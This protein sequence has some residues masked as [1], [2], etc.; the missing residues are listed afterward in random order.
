MISSP[1]DEIKNRL[2]VV[3][4]IGSYIKLQKAGANFR[5][6]CPF[7]SEKNPSLFISPARQIWHC[8]G[9]FL[10]G[11]LIKT[12]RG[13]HE[14]EDIRVGERVLTHEGNYLPVIR[15]LWRPYQGEII[16]IKLRKSNEITSL[17]P[18][19]EVYVIKTKH[20]KYESR[21][22]RI[23]QWNCRRC[24]KCKDG[25]LGRF[26]LNYKIEKLPVAQLSKDDYLLYPINQEI[27]DIEFIDLNKYYNRRISNFGPDIKEIPTFVK[28]DE[29]FLK[30]IGY[31]IAE[32]SNHRAYIRFSLGDHEKEF[33]KEI[34]ELIRD[35][36]G[37]KAAIHK[38]KK[39][40]K[41]GLEISACNS[42]L[43]NIFE[44]LCG[45]HG[46]NK[47]ILFK[48]QY[49]SPEKQRIIL[50]AIWRG[51]GTERKVD[52]CKRER[53]S[54]SISTTS[55]ILAEQLR[56]ILLR[57]KIA[58]AFF[59][60]EEKIDKKGVHHKK[61][62]II[63]WEENYILNY[64]GFYQ[65]GEILY[66]LCPIKEI[67]KR[68]Y[69]GDTFDLTIAKDHSYVAANFLV[70]NCG[71]GGDIFGFVKEI[72]GV[73]FG[74]ALRILARRA[75][76][77]LKREDP[78]I[79]T[80]RRR[81]YEICELSTQFF[82]K[83]LESKT[84]QEVNDYLRKRGINQESIEKWRLG[85][86]PDSWNSLSDFLVSKGY[87][88]EEIER[89]G[90]VIKNESGN[91][92]DRFRGRIIFPVFDLNSQVIGFGGR[93][94]SVNQRINQ[95]ESASTIAKYVNTPNTSLYDKS[96]VL[97]GL[98]KAKVEIRKKDF[99]ILVEG[100]VDV[101]M[102]HQTG[103]ENTAATSGTALSP[104]QLAILK[105]YSE[106]I[107]TAFDMDVAGDWATKRGIDLAQA[108]GFD[109]KV[110]TMPQDSDPADIISQN[111]EKW[112]ELVEKAKSI[113]DFYFESAFS[114]FD[115]KP[116][117]GKKE[118]SKILLPVIKRIPNK[119]EQSFWVQKLA[120]ELEVGEGDVAE[121]LN[122]IKLTEEVYGLEPEEIV[123][124]PSKT[125][126]ELLEERLIT[127]ILISK[128]P[129]YLESI[130]EAEFSNFS[131]KSQEILK[132]L[133]NNKISQ[134]G[135]D[136]SGLSPESVDLLNY[137][138]LK[139]EIEEIEK[140]EI[141][142]EIKYCIKEIRSIEIKNKLD[143]ISKEIKKAEEE[144]DASKIQQLIKEFNF[145]S[146]T[147]SDL[148]L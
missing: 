23:C 25:K 45:L 81:I 4:V 40:T 93:I 42:K 136:E 58:P 98:D 55:L 126:K 57:L 83:Q 22:T 34:K 6:L 104:Y 16:E 65:A 17:T 101:I 86:S 123:N 20:C 94:F 108:R 29:K 148:N 7:H 21:K 147:L 39:G 143:Q 80:E 41:T 32:G 54:K 52:K 62:Y 122:K 128:S 91:F 19:H 114:K 36:F 146:K 56:D 116:P 49:L 12:E 10:P 117:Q 64:S 75:G 111:P 140:K 84:G 43:S 3:E 11:S 24:K 102:C 78:K 50:D 48:F 92:Y 35:I 106:K 38:R 53:Y 60:Q 68:Y 142:P 44:N 130:K 79:K 71:K 131:P 125:R 46:E 145:H 73:E 129:H 110:I 127:L 66:W 18:D 105:R 27:R 118:I 82:E 37:I 115:S 107:L 77:E 1:I 97:Y 76:V 59:I 69:Q 8:F 139:A 99:V 51:D 89:A 26:Y 74:D 113:L 134:K 138:Y 96:K 124:L 133:K 13:F 135:L 90:L 137:F 33:A 61:S 88:K 95:R 2:D 109:V 85:Y 144:K 132:H 63:E 141:E 5:A 112:K 87:K 28:V 31:Y 121:E 100:Y 47:H 15:T 70:S 103:F 14:I 9:C 72:E 67:K 120:K 119:I 30:L